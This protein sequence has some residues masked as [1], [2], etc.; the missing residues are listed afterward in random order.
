MNPR[1]RILLILENF[2]RIG[3]IL[4][5]AS[6]F[7]H[8]EQAAEAVRKRAGSK[9]PPRPRYG[10]ILGTGLGALAQG[11]VPTAEI[12]FAEIPGFPQ[13]TAAGHAGKLIV[14]TLSGKPVLVMEGRLHFYEGHPIDRIVFPV[15][16][17]KAL[18]VE[19][20]VVSNACGGM[21][22]NFRKGDLM[23]IDDHINLMGINPLI[24]PNDDR[25]GPRFPDMCRSYDPALLDLAERIARREGI[26]AHRGVYAAV[27]GP[28]L[29]TRA[30]Y[31]FL[32]GIGADAVG[33][34]TV[35]EVI[36]G[37]HAGLR[38]LGVSCVTDLCFPDALHPV[39]I[40]E[41]IAVAAEAE[42]KLSRLVQCV[43][44]ES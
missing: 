7:N 43:I 33:M 31:R 29:E 1:A 21:N 26:R 30:E 8:I 10:V 19:I 13:A 17:L 42:P 16:V 20:L 22:P 39:N 24:G 28:N 6:L 32:R 4:S 36:V 34:S 27:T 5:M 35:P 38:I 25:L 23:L 9:S 40:Q 11:V 3:I 12:P 2:D 41:I 14:G 15:R 18:G 37:V 44:A